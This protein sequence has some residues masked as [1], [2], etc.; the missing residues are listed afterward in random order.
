MQSWFRADLAKPEQKPFS[1]LLATARIPTPHDRTKT[2][3]TG[4]PDAKEIADITSTFHTLQRLDVRDL[5]IS[6]S[7]TLQWAIDRLSKYCPLV[8]EEADQWTIWKPPKTIFPPIQSEKDTMKHG[9]YTFIEPALTAAI[10]LYAQHYGLSPEEAGCHPFGNWA[11]QDRSTIGSETRTDLV[12]AKLNMVGRTGKDPVAV[13]CE[14][15]TSHV[16]RSNGFP[17]DAQYSYSLFILPELQ[18]W[19]ERDNTIPIVPFDTSHEDASE[20]AWQRKLRNI[21]LQVCTISPSTSTF[22]AEFHT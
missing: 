22:P 6:E 5:K 2:T 8:E 14:A 17:L 9:Q 20:R 12:I 3:K 19:L 4:Q 1:T 11:V 15:K 10:F 7:E 13:V 21:L 18:R 16:C